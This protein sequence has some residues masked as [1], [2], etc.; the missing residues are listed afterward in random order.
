MVPSR[1]SFGAWGLTVAVPEVVCLHVRENEI[2]AVYERVRNVMTSSL[3]HDMQR[4][5]LLHPDTCKLA[6]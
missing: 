6:T 4:S 5:L 3:R 2:R 1:T